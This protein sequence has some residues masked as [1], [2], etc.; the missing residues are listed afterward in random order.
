MPDPMHCPVAEQAE[1]TSASALTL[2]GCVRK[3]RRLQAQC[4]GCANADA[5]DAVRMWRTSIDT[6][7]TEIL[8]EWKKMPA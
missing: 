6:A 7:V 3:L 2:A 4:G 1:L 5:C 8:A